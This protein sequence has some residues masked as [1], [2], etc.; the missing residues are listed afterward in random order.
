MEKDEDLYLIINEES[1][2]DDDDGKFSLSLC[3]FLG[4]VQAS[5]AYFAQIRLLQWVVLVFERR[6]KRERRVRFGMSW[7]LG[8]D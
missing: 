5:N 2:D 8:N 3:F 7:S 1:D 4:D 6:R